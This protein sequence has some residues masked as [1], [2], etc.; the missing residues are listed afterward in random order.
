MAVDRESNLEGC[1]AKVRPKLQP[2]TA[3]G[4]KAWLVRVKRWEWGSFM[5]ECSLVPALCVTTHQSPRAL[6]H[7]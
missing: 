7:C 5:V 3:Y 6:M 4:G 1:S 2:C